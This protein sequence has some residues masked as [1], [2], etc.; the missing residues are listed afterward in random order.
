MKITRPYDNEI[1]L[2]EDFVTDKELSIMFEHISKSTSGYNN[3]EMTNNYFNDKVI[4][5]SPEDPYSKEEMSLPIFVVR[6]HL[7]ERAKEVVL[8]STGKDLEY[9]YIDFIIKAHG[10]GMSEHYDD[11]PLVKETTTEY[12]LVIYLNDNY[13]GGEIY[14]PNLDIEIK[15]IAKS[16]IIH[17]GTVEYTHG[18]RDTTVGER[19]C[20]TFF[21]LSRNFWP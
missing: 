9:T 10:K 14:Y 21:A 4:K 3:E 8:A 2:V 17:P 13:E 16:L 15:P 20:I 19:F 5:F 7:S 11:T 1:I 18:V 12:G 6:S